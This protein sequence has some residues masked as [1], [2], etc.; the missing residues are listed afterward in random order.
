MD[1]FGK[2][3]SPIPPRHSYFAPDRRIAEVKVTTVRETAVMESLIVPSAEKAVEIFRDVVT[4]S[5]WFDPEKECA[6]VL[7]LNVKGRAIGYN[8]LS[9]GAQTT[10]ICHCREVLRA[11][12]VA[13][14]VSIVVFHNHP[15]G[16]P[17]SS[18]ADTRVTKELNAAAKVVGVTLIDHVIVGDVRYDPL[19]RG[20]FSFRDA[21]V[22]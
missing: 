8:L 14:A 19:E 16:D 21:G 22:I 6:V 7:F 5:D 20:Y 12:L 18:P 11:A 10:V 1:F 13:N 2:G 9:I 17:A 3:V 4:K 15:S